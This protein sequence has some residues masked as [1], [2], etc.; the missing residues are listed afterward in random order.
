LWGT[1]AELID[2]ALTTLNVQPS[3]PVDTPEKSRA[4]VHALVRHLDVGLHE[5]PVHGQNERRR[6]RLAEAIGEATGRTADA[7]RLAH[8][9]A[10]AVMYARLMTGRRLSAAEL[11]RLVDLVLGPAP[12]QVR[13]RP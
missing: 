7:D 6:A 8:A 1:K 10:G 4:A 13:S 9:L 5:G 11:E 12:S 3:D 2:A